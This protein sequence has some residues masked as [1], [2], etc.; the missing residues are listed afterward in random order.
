MYPEQR[1]AAPK[2]CPVC[3]ST[4]LLVKQQYNML[5]FK[6]ENCGFQHFE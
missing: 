6:C 2:L 4:R 3:N 5:R 1:K